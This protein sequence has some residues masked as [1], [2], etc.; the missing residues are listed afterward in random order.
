[1]VMDGSHFKNPLSACLFKICHLNNNRCNF[2]KINKPYD[3]NKQRHLHHICRTCHKAS[4]R[5]R[6]GIPHKYAGRINIKKQEAK[7][8]ADHRAGNRLHTAFRS[9]CNHRKERRYQHCD[10]GC[11]AVKAVC[12][13]RAVYCA[14]HGN[15]Q[16]RNSHPADIK[17]ISVRERHQHSQRHFRHFYKVKGK[18]CSHYNLESHL[19][20]RQQ[21]V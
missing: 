11:Q 7:E 10:A 8:R 13:I 9:N 17:V 12:K 16:N 1:M 18:Y 6:T 21:A 20:H 4:E 5:E 19:L 15:K 3:N 14:D 2:H